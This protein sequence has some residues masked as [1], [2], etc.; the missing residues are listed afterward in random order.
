MLLLSVGAKR[1]VILSFCFL[2]PL[3]KELVQQSLGFC[4]LC[5]VIAEFAPNVAD[6][7]HPN[8]FTHDAVVVFFSPLSVGL[9]S[10][11]STVSPFF[12]F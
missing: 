8:Y 1:L 9:K 2:G 6:T 5:P 7:S 12:V 10:N 11:A 3:V 4:S